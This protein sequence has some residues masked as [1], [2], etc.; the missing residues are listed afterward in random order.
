MYTRLNQ[1][2]L[3][4]MHESFLYIEVHVKPMIVLKI[5]FIVAFNFMVLNISTL[6]Q[7]HEDTE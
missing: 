4:L 5:C 6:I 2:F 1:H 7:E 3:Q